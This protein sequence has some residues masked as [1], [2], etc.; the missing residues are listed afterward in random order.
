MFSIFRPSVLST[1]LKE[2]STTPLITNFLTL[3]LKHT[4]LRYFLNLI[5][6]Y[7]WSNVSQRRVAAFAVIKYLY[8]LENTLFCLFTGTITLKIY[9]LSFKWVSRPAELPRR[10]LAKRCVNLSVH[11]ASIRQIPFPCFASSV[12]TNAAP[13][14]QLFSERCLLWFCFL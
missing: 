12:Q 5:F 4:F 13:F 11:T 6:K 1:R 8:I 14:R 2:S 9:V 7:R 10:P 3:N